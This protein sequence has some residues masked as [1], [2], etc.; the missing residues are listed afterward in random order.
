[1]AVEIKVI[2]RVLG[3][4]NSCLGLVN[5]SAAVPQLRTSVYDSHHEGGLAVLRA[6]EDGSRNVRVFLNKISF[7]HHFAVLK[8]DREEPMR[9]FFATWT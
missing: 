9:V 2:C 1:M 7:D 8:R 4:K 5:P 6:G 3:S